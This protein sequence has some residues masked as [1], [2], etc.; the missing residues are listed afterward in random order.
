MSSVVAFVLSMAVFSGMQVYRHQLASSGPLTVL[1]GGLG[2]TLFLFILSAVGNLELVLFGKGFQTGL[3]P[4]V[5]LCLILALV[6]SGM[7][8]GVCI[9]TCLIFSIITLYYV[10]RISQSTYSTQPTVANSHSTSSKKK[11]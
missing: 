7:V 2:A 1:G 6:A 5:A 4:E 3:F 9:T 11:K 10:N 8:H